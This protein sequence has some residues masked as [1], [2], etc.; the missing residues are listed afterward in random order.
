RLAWAELA[1]WSSLA[2]GAERRA[3][4]LQAQG[5]SEKD[6]LERGVRPV[7][8]IAYARLGRL[9][10]ARAV[11]ATL[12]VDCEP[13]LD[14][15]GWV[16]ALSGDPAGADRWFALL[17]RMAPDLPFYDRDWGEVLLARGEVDHAIAKLSQAHVK[18]PRFADPM[19]LWGEAL[20]AK[21]NYP[22]AVAKFA[23]ADKDAPRWGRNHLVWGEA[24]MLLGRYAKSRAQYLAANDMDLSGPDRAALKVLLARTSSGPLH[25]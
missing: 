23:D 25:G 15:R 18:G 24:L 5:P 14:A 19:E 6:Y 16:A 22:G 10:E 8:A 12:P 21:R 3:A 7:L 11:A 1:D 4:A 2:T 20:M 13:R 9:E 17:D